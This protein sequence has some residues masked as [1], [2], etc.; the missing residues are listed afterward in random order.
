M[1]KKV[2]PVLLAVVLVFGLVLGC[3][4]SKKSPHGPDE[5]EEVFDRAVELEMPFTIVNNANQK[6][7]KANGCDDDK[8]PFETKLELD[9]F[10]AAKFLVLE[11]GTKPTGGLQIIWQG[12]KNSGWAWTQNDEV[13]KNG[14]GSPDPA[15]GAKWRDEEKLILEIELKKAMKSYVNLKKCEKAKIYLGYYSPNVDELGITR[16]Y[17]EIYKGGEEKPPVITKVTID[18]K[19]ASVKQGASKTFTAEVEGEN[20]YDNT[21]TWTVSGTG[22][23]AGTT[24]TAEGKLTVD[25]DEPPDTKITVKATAKGDDTKSDTATVTVTEAIELPPPSVGFVNLGDFNSEG[26]A[27]HTNGLDGAV[28]DLT[29]EV[30]ASAKYLI[31][32]LHSD[33][34]NGVGGLQLGFTGNAFP[35][36]AWKDPVLTKDWTGLHTILGPYEASLDFYFVVDL[37]TVPDWDELITGDQA[38]IYLNDPAAWTKDDY[39]FVAGYLASINLTKPATFV[40]AEDNGGTKHGWFALDVPELNGEKG[41]V[42]YENGA[43]KTGYDGEAKNENNNTAITFYSN[44]I[45]TTGLTKVYIKYTTAAD[46]RGGS[47][48]GD[49]TTGSVWVNNAY[50]SG[51]NKVNPDETGSTDTFY[52]EFTLDDKTVGAFKKL[53][54]GGENML[55]NIVKIWVE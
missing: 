45:D 18:P 21:V 9:D 33:K 23:K 15:K 20:D 31:V 10:K 53:M 16:A 17:L 5:N 50:W 28:N 22:L 14:D 35:N 46:Y 25:A 8:P 24:I 3:G 37:S 12:D 7:W 13:L 55:P 48:E 41:I 27:W 42:L 29:A 43:W 51:F 36:W 40:D 44:P 32:K 6:G 19:T 49:P 52:G 1:M 34:F 11:L 39:S 47:V 26:K 4:G 2:W 54:I 30:L 38:K